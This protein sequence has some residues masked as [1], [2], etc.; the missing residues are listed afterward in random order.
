MHRRVLTILGVLFFLSLAA[1]AGGGTSGTSTG[2]GNSV[3]VQGRILF[4]DGS[5]ASNVDL[6][7]VMSEAIARTDAEGN[8]ELATTDAPRSFELLVESM[9]LSATVVLGEFSD[10]T[11]VISTELVLDLQS[12]ALTVSF[13]EVNPLAE[14]APTDDIAPDETSGTSP[15][16]DTEEPEQESSPAPDKPS[17]IPEEPPVVEDVP[18]ENVL[19][20]R[21]TLSTEAGAPVSGASI[22]LPQ[23]GVSTTTDSS[24]SFFFDLRDFSGL[25]IVTVSTSEIEESVGI[26]N[27]PNSDVEIRLQLSIQGGDASSAGGGDEV[28]G[29]GGEAESGEESEML[30]LIIEDLV[31]SS[32]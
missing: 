4:S 20:I 17:V 16:D 24:G 10:E 12:G 15:A 27:I 3:I 21:G 2:T 9:M 31:I 32:L 8:F 26:E 22:S 5:P 19:V 13:I 28:I 7:L 1:C 6:T 29:V 30:E 14:S 11:N 25:L 18:E 23:L